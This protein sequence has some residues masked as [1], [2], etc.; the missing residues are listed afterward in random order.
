VAA[1]REDAYLRGNCEREQ[2]SAPCRRRSTPVFLHAWSLPQD[3]WVH[4]MLPLSE[5]G[6]RCISYDRR[7]H[8]RSTDPG[9]GY[10]YDT[11]SD[12]L[13][14]VLE[15]LDLRDVTLVGYSF[16]AGEI[17]RYFS[18]HGSARIARVAFV[19]PCGPPF[20]T[21]TP[22]NPDGLDA[23]YFAGEQAK[24]RFSF[25][26]WLEDNKAPFF[27]HETPAVV[28]DWT[29]RLMLQ[30]SAKAAL[31]CMRIMTSTDFRAE[32]ANITVPAI[33]IHGDRD[34]SAPIDLTGRKTAAA[35]PG[36]RLEVYAGGPHGIFF[37]HAERLTADIKAFALG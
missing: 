5:Q 7:G 31:E 19:A 33:V 9:V 6:F 10:D 26:A 35:I 21:K 29:I 2:H 36:A 34:M 11:L 20:M 25:A 17:V 15:A 3:M 23:A 37:T 28:T 18:R 22:D 12:D 8:G 30:T 24:V 13:A 32:L 16:A 14:C 4:Q 1:L 27:T